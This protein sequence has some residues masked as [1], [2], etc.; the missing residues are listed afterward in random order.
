MTS[1]I[2][3]CEKPDAKKIFVIN[4]SPQRKA[5]GTMRVTK[6]FLKGIEDNCSC[7]IEICTLSDMNIKPCRGCLYCW[8]RTDG[9]CVIA[10][11]DIPLIKQKFLDADVLIESFPLYF[12]GMP[13]ALKNMTD[14]LL[15]VMLPYR[16]E[17]PEIGQPYHAFRYDMSEKKIILISTCGISQAMP[18]Y[19]SLIEQFD[20]ILGKNGYQALLC[21]QGKVFSASSA[22]TLNDKIEIY[23]QRYTDAGAEFAKNGVLS[24]KTIKFLQEPIFDERTF[25]LLINEFWRSEREIGKQA[26]KNVKGKLKRETNEYF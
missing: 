22:P 6:A 3:T 26:Q 11:D 13:G 15:S 4:G 8:G 14:R 2:S 7:E 10:D 25:Q 1:S 19:K 23:L 16:G 21:P 18:T 9:E 24:E 17:T 5:S 20:C 12:F